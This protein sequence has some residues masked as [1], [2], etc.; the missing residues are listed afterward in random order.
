MGQFRSQNLF[1]LLMTIAFVVTFILPARTSSKLRPQAGILFAP[2]SRPVAA[3]A[4]MIGGRTQVVNANDHRSDDSVR[5]ENESLRAEVSRLMAVLNESSRRDRELA[6]LGAIK[7][8]CVVAQ[9]AGADTS[10][11]ESI[12]LVGR[13]L[14]NVKPGMYALTRQGLV[15]RIESVAA[16]SAQVRLISDPNMRL[17]CQFWSFAGGAASVVPLSKVI[18]EG[19]GDGAMIVRQIKLADLRLGPSMQPLDEK[20]GAALR[21][22]DYC[23]LADPEC[24]APLQGQYVGRVEGIYPS[25]GGRLMA[26]VMIRPATSLK[27]LSEAMIL[28]QE[29]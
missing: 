3:I 27:R 24:P 6:G 13:S 10:G 18:V 7:D 15:G 8:R 4:R 2:V 28:N 20:L 1:Y 17:Q 21:E 16:G 23:L 5:M 22:G 9:V 29:R 19:R 25:P 12:T 14:L 11:R 26:D